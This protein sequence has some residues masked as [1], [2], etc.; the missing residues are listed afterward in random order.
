MNYCLEVISKSGELLR[1]FHA[2]NFDEAIYL[3]I[4]ARELK[5]GIV[6]VFHNGHIVCAMRVL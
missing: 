3:A 6:Q 1:A 5:E 4:K 2:E